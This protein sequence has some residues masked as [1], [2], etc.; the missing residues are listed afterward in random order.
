MENHRATLA[1]EPQTLHTFADLPASVGQVSAGPLG[2]VARRDHSTWRTKDRS[3]PGYWA[4]RVDCALGVWVQE[5]P[6]HRILLCVGAGVMVGLVCR[7]R[8]W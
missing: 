5:Q 3:D 7:S 1:V 6:L 8:E 2:A 4:G